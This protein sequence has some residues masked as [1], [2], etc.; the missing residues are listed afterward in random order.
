MGVING[1]KG[2]VFAGRKEKGDIYG[3]INH[4]N[5]KF[6]GNFLILTH[7]GYIV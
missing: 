3:N 6:L 7:F 2:D 5:P 4:L 1:W